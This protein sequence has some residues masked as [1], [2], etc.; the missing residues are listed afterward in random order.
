M[1]SMFKGIANIASVTSHRVGASVQFSC[2]DSYVLQGSKSI[3][4]QRVTETLA[5]WSDHRPICRTRTCGSNLRGPRGL[6]TSPNYPVQY[7]NNAHCVWVIT[8]LDT[9]KV[10]KLSFEEFE[11]ERGYDTLTVGDGGKI[12]DTR[13]VLYV[14]TGSSVP[15]LIVSL[16]NQMWLHLQSDDTIGS[17]GF[18]AQ[19]RWRCDDDGRPAVATRS[20]RKSPFNASTAFAQLRMWP[21]D[22]VAAAVALSGARC[23]VMRVVLLYREVQCI[24]HPVSGP[25]TTTSSTSTTTTTTTSSTTAASLG[26]VSFI[27]C[28][29]R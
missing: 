12:G 26:C 14:L 2:D 19:R 1:Q 15:D 27:S 29:K 18:K 21:L 5:A 9:D 7:E 8:T 13:R 20:V 3:T 17:Q 22:V 4:C 10:I 16:T 28:L 11:L 6:I 25:H 23:S 24:S